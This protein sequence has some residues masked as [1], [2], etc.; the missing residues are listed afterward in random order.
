MSALVLN[1]ENADMPEL[2][3]DDLREDF[4]ESID[5][6]FENVYTSKLLVQS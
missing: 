4:D 2:T 6:N 3:E 5:S 1:R